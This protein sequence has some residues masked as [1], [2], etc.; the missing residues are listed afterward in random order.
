MPAVFGKPFVEAQ[1]VLDTFHIT[2][3]KNIH[4]FDIANNDVVLVDTSGDDPMDPRIDDTRVIEI[5]DHHKN[6]QLHRF[7]N[8][9]AQIEHIGA[10]ATLVAERMK[11]AN[12]TPSRES[13]ILL[14]GGII[15][16]TMNFCSSNVA[17]KDQDMHDWLWNI[18]QPPISFAHEMFHAKTN[19]IL[20][21]L[22]SA[23]RT[24]G[25]CITMNDIPIAQIQ[26][27]L[28]DVANLF[29]NRREELEIL[30]KKIK[31]EGGARFA[32]LSCI[33]VDKK[34]TDI[35]VFD[36]ESREF[37]T[38][39]LGLQFPNNHV[40]LDHILLRKQMI[41]PIKETLKKYANKK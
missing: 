30:M 2:S 38:E 39:A 7:P 36:D 20:Q 27:E 4:E 16:N 34:T 37:Y 21:D 8:A 1:W 12:Y 32:L 11:Q 5:I 10:A 17:Q 33:D 35:L 40:H 15:S 6:N 41:M 23:L 3:P 28:V 9:I 26:L 31:K 19:L 18:A 14:L 22:D 29:K 13:A 25:I 24:E